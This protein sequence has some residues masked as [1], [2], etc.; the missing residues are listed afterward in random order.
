MSGV[1]K[2]CDDQMEFIMVFE[3]EIDAA[4]YCDSRNWELV[5]EDGTV[6]NLDYMEV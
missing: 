5:D 4:D 6:W 1:F 3:Y 2:Y